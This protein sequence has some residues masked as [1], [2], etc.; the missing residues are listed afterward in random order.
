MLIPRAAPRLARLLRGL[1]WATA[2]LNQLSFLH[3]S[4]LFIPYFRAEQDHQARA[5]S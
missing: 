3:N 2:L 1:D 5:V 4:S